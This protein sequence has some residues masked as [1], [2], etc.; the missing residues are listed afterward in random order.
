MKHVKPSA[1]RELLRL[2]ADP[3]IISFGGGYPDATLF[4]PEQLDAVFSRSIIE[5]GHDT[6]LASLMVLDKL[7]HRADAG[8]H[9]AHDVAGWIV[10]PLA[11]ALMGL[12]LWY[13]S[14]LIVEVRAVNPPVG[15]GEP[16]F[17]KIDG[18]IGQAMLRP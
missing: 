16:T 14:R 7:R 1:I 3:S 6:Q 5:H 10:I 11:A 17:D 8:R 15:L 4:P 9:L 18:L 12:F 13:L 2:G